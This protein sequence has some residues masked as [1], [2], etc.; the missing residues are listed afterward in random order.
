MY[1]LEANVLD[2]LREDIQLVFMFLKDVSV[3]SDSRLP[4]C[5]R[6]TLGDLAY[7]QFCGR[8]ANLKE[9]VMSR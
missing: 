8:F 2:G 7:C 9:G 5:L 4:Y 6:G 3:T 1:E